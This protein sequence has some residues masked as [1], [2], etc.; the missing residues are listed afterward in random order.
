MVCHCLSRFQDARSSVC[1]ICE[2]LQTL[3]VTI[4]KINW[5]PCSSR[6][7]SKVRILPSP[8]LFEILTQQLSW[9]WDSRDPQLV[10]PIDKWA[11]CQV[12]YTIKMKV[13]TD[14]LA[15]ILIRFGNPLRTFT[16]LVDDVEI[17][18]NKHVSNDHLNFLFGK[19]RPYAWM[20]SW[21]SR[22]LDT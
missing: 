20:T 17:E 10:L 15:F 9:T 6:L 21:K 2:F 7:Y 22:R 11:G 18:G 8:L 14:L 5:L 19:F 16:K 13:P 4:S 12:W 1:L 3:P